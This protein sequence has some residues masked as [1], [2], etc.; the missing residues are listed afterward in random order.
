MKKEATR[1][2][3]NV[4]NGKGLTLSSRPK[5]IKNPWNEDEQQ[6]FI[7]ALT[8]YGPKKM[9]E[10]ADHIRTR[11]VTQVRSHLQKH[12]LK[13]ERKPQYLKPLP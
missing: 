8:K 3:G 5:Q 2:M 6:S 10:I 4:S 7:E 12:R 11:S 9:K 1:D 13:E